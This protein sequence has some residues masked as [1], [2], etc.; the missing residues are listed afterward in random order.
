MAKTAKARPAK[1]YGRGKS[2]GCS[3]GETLKPDMAD[4][5]WKEKGSYQ[6]LCGIKSIDKEEQKIR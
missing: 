3:M 5:V 4:H 2:K 6:T 1:S